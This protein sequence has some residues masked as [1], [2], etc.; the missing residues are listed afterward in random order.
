MSLAKSI[1]LI[2]DDPDAAG[3]EIRV[4]NTGIGIPIDEL[5][6]LFSRFHRGRNATPYPGS[7]LGLAIVNVIV[8]RHG[9]RVVAENID[10]GARFTIQLPP[11]FR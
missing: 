2:E 6:Q 7:G 10:N 11:K 5:P 3:I 4:E 9:G 1:L 8:E